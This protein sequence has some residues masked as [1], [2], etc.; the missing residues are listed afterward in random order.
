MFDKKK[1]D[2]FS[3]DFP[4]ENCEIED[5]T[6]GATHFYNPNTANMDEKWIKEYP[7]TFK[8]KNHWFA[9]GAF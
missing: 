6:G 7:V 1:Y 2:N 5:I 4:S 8:L 9:K 3:P